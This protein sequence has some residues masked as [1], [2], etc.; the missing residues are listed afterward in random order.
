LRYIINTSRGQ[1]HQPS[2]PS[3]PTSVL[4]G[5]NLVSLSQ[6]SGLCESLITLG[7]ANDRR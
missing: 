3:A 6:A 1:N 4:V 5:I 2:Q 7:W